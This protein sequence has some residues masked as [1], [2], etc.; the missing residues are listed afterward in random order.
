M[1]ASRRQYGKADQATAD[2]F[3]GLQPKHEPA[4]RLGS[5]ARKSQGLTEP[6]I[7]SILVSRMTYSIADAHRFIETGEQANKIVVTA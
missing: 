2:R 6:Y 7:S 3:G 4:P 5:P 1:T